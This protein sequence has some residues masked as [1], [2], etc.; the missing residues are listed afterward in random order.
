MRDLNMYRS[1]SDGVCS[2]A[3]SICLSAAAVS[4][5]TSACCAASTRTH[6]TVLGNSSCSLSGVS[7]PLLSRHCSHS[8]MIWPV[9]S[10]VASIAQSGFRSAKSDG[11]PLRR[12]GTTYAA[13]AS[14]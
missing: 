7:L 1:S 11:T 14:R 2:M 6:S 8:A 9:S 4:P 13:K 12:Y 5:H 3:R 10:R